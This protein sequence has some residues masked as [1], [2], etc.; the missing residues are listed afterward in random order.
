M[1]PILKDVKKEIGDTVTII[2]VDVNKSPEAVN[3]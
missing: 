2:K 1:T 3:Q